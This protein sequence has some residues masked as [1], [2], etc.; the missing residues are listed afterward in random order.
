MAWV[1]GLVAAVTLGVL[2]MP[3]PLWLSLMAR[4]TGSSAQQAIPGVDA[5]QPEMPPRTP[6]VTPVIFA[7]R[8]QE[9][10]KA[11]RFSLKDTQGQ[12][13]RLEKLLGDTP[14]I[15]EFGSRTCDP[16]MGQVGAMN[17]L[18][19]RYQGKAKILFIYCREAHPDPARVS[20]SE[21]D[22]T[23]ADEAARVTR[24]RERQD[25]AKTMCRL[26]SK[27]WSVLVDEMAEQSVYHRFVLGLGNPLFVVDRDGQ[28]A[29]A[30]EWTDA[31]ELDKFLQRFVVTRH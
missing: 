8:L 6:G 28:I 9:G 30:M 15:I 10:D 13:V 2:L 21:D 29:L 4:W 7:L 5:Q 20:Q 11:P 25:A 23:F 27:D 1:L 26:A 18:A 31:A 16:C 17:R 24:M 22:E 3:M 14:I 19:Q 12:M